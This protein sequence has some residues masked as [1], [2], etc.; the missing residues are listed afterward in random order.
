[1]AG[2]SGDAGD[3]FTH[4]DPLYNTNGMLF[5]TPDEDNDI[6]PGGSCAFNRAAG[7][8]YAHCSISQLTKPANQPYAA[9]VFYNVQLSRMLVK[10]N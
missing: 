5:S 6:W 8:W 7:W 9:W 3:A 1:M 10:L 4:V 2:Y